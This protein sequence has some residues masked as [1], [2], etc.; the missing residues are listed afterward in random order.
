MS[1][2]EKIKVAEYSQHIISIFMH[3]NAYRKSHKNCWRSIT[4]CK[5]EP[6]RTVIYV[7][8]FRKHSIEMNAINRCPSESGQPRVMKADCDELAGKLMEE[9]L[10]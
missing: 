5:V 9:I 10:E 6:H 7:T 2:Q 8:H 4:D 3:S 1:F